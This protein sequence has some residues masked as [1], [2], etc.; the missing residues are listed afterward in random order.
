MPIRY[1]NG[2]KYRWTHR[3]KEHHVDWGGLPKGG[4]RYPLPL[5]QVGDFFVITDPLKMEQTRGALYRWEKRFRE[6]LAASKSEKAVPVFSIRPVKGMPDIYICR[7][8][9]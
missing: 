6:A 4:T 1:D 9:H 7:R 8:T 3:C 5:M 2:E